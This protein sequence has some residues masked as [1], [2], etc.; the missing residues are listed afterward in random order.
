MATLAAAR[1][2]P[3]PP[4]LRFR[5]P[6]PFLTRMK[7]D[8]LGLYRE[9]WRQGDFVRF[10]APLIRAYL[11]VHPDAVKHVLQDNHRNYWKGRIFTRLRRFSG[12][13][14]LF[15]EGE[16]WRRQRR[17]SNPAFRR[18]RL[19]AMADT[20]AARA[21]RMV[22]RWERRGPEEPFDLQWETSGYAL[23]VAVDA[24]LGVEELSESAW[25]RETMG[26]AMDYAN[27]LVNT[28]L[29]A[30]LWVPTARNRRMSREMAKLRGLLD[31]IIAEHRER[32]D[33]DD[34]L[35]M[36]LEARD[37][38]GGM[39]DQQL[40]DELIT[41]MTAGHETSGVT[42]SW[43]F[44]L[45][46][47]HPKALGHLRDELASVLGGRPPRAED[48]DDLV[49]TR[50]V[51]EET[52]R[53][54]PPAWTLARESL[55]PDTIAGFPIPRRASVLMSP[56]LTHRHPEFWDDPEAFDPTRFLPERS[57][58]RHAMAYLPFGGG[59]RKCIGVHFAMLELVLAVASIAQRVHLEPVAGRPV[60]ED[61][62]F[63][64]RARDGI[65]MR[66]RPLS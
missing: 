40:R 2:S 58:G 50:A 60:V 5:G 28:F 3:G 12:N 32:G 34:L 56:Y 33:A 57:R 47:E 43:A 29:P 24:L 38:E 51:V 20:M 4:S 19:L 45:L 54:R 7:G 35:G 30:P 27:H 39:G 36:L 64:L 23:E 11:A 41:F 31:R 18:P 55:A 10:D 66:A 8:P 1:P 25:M 13:G 63:T 42:L 9:A 17:L 46:A 49:W 14:V 22:E 44:H 37:E 65:W 15:S 53:V 16:L 52:M 59:P 62:I 6:L 48:L 61:P 21:E 26:L